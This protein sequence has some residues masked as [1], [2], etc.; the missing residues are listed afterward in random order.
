M[1]RMLAPLNN[2]R[3]DCQVTKFLQ[4]FTYIITDFKKLTHPA[5]KT[6]RQAD[7]K[8]EIFMPLDLPDQ[9]FN[10]FKQQT[11]SGITF[12]HVQPMTIKVTHRGQF[13]STQL[14]SVCSHLPVHFFPPY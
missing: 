1:T 7:R 2:L 3:S 5:A 4:I 6:T 9:F 12:L 10:Y 13:S 8:S 14:R 11:D